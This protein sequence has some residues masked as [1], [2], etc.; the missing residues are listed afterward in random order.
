MIP[1]YQQSDLIV[2]PKLQIPS[3]RLIELEIY[4]RNHPVTGYTVVKSDLRN[5]EEETDGD[6]DGE[7]QR[8]RAPLSSE[9]KSDQTKMSSTQKKLGIF[10]K[11]SQE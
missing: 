7:I 4:Q 2:P 11:P 10:T 9:P 1:G 6:R 3:I 5:S 8:N